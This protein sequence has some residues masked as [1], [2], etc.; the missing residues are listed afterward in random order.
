LEDKKK[1]PGSASQNKLKKSVQAIN[2]S[3]II[4][5]QV[6]GMNDNNLVS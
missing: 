5:E 6:T 1:R 4:A 2:I 3:R